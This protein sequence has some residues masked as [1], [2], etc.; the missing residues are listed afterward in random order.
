MAVDW[1]SG[2]RQR[3]DFLRAIPDQCAL[4]D[5]LGCIENGSR[6]GCLEGGGLN[7]GVGTF[8]GSEDH[9]AIMSCNAN[10]LKIFSFCPT[11]FV[12][13]VILTSIYIYIYN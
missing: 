4:C 6:F 10:T 7:A 8:G 11:K 9:T 3:S 1:S 13:E 2:L 5:Y 12:Q